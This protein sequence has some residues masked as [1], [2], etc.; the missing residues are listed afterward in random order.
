MGEKIT[1]N[2]NKK[3][4]IKN[5]SGANLKKIFI[6]GYN[7]LDK[8]KGFI[9][10]LNVFPVPDGDTGL[11]M[12]LTMKSVLKEIENVATS[13]ITELSSGIARGALKGAR[14][15]SGVIT[16][17]ILKGMM[18]VFGKIG[19]AK[20][21]TKVFADAIKEGAKVAYSAVT[22]PKEGTI[23]TVIRVMGAEAEKIAKGTGD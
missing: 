16:S 14:G 5:L 20:I 18:S 4:V 9:D 8:N 1:E 17:Q 7:L 6:G 11:N 21:T 13:N 12:S 23:L 22:V 10:A 2:K 15:N 3:T 19:D